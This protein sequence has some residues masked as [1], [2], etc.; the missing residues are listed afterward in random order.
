MHR[1][2]N[3]TG[4][5]T[6]MGNPQKTKQMNKKTSSKA[7]SYGEQSG[8]DRGRA[9]G[10]GRGREEEREEGRRGRKEGGAGVGGVG[11]GRGEEGD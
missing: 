2:I 4:K 10:M 8:V 11:R 1:K 3:E 9:C 5:D 7:Y 6:C